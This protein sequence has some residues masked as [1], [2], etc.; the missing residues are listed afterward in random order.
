SGALI[1]LVLF[2][3]ALGVVPLGT[4]FSSQ[5]FL[6]DGDATRAAVT[7][8]VSANFVLVGYIILSVRED[9]RERERATKVAESQKTR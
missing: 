8:I 5:R 3:I 4:Y 6:Y 1:K 2:S 9:K 7:A